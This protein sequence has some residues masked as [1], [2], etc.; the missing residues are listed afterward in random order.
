MLKIGKKM[1]FI[2]FKSGGGRLLEHGHLLGI[3]RYLNKV[4][5]QKIK[6]QT[7]KPH[8]WGH[9]VFTQDAMKDDFSG[10]FF[11]ISEIIIFCFV[12]AIFDLVHDVETIYSV[13]KSNGP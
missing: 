4:S 6:L 8:I 2:V 3:L 11:R 7:F 10:L 12:V 5:K 1:P 9:C 13:K